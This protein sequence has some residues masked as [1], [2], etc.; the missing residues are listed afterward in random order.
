MQA[1]ILL[2]G[3]TGFFGRALLRYF[4]MSGMAVD[5]SVCVLSRDPQRFR[6]EHP[7]L[8]SCEGISI[9]Q[10]DVE[11]RSSLPWY[12]DFTHV[13]HAATDSSAG[14]HLSPLQRFN[15]IVVGTTNILDLAVATGANRFL[16]TSSGGIYG[17]QPDDLEAIPES[18]L[19][20]PPLVQTSSAYSHGKRTAEHLCM[21]YRETYGLQVIVAR[22]F[23]FVGADLPLD[24][25]FAIGNFIRDA[26]YHDKIVVRG[27]GTPLRTYM[28]QRDLA[29]WL[30]ELLY[31]GTD[32]EAYNVGSDRVISIAELADLVRDLLAP[33]KQ[34]HVLDDASSSTVR[35]RYIPSIAK[36]QALHD[37]RLAVT[38]EQAI[39]STADAHRKKC[40]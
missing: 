26:L 32:G 1:R 37:L 18:W 21:L 31:H 23:T 25:H 28:D 20:S 2:T 34:V 4:H 9:L 27:D 19:G 8:V 38:L 11:D 12:S 14:P 29:H 36:I 17:P 22:C 15:Q 39:I 24:I 35:N 13:F 3:G 7:D 6:A 30:W 5:S 16:L 40:M 33:H 10:A